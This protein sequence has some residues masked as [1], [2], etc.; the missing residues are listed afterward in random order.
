MPV[1]EMPD[2]Q[3][4][5]FPEDT[6]KEEILALIDQ[7]EASISAEEAP[8]EPEVVE[9]KSEE[10]VPKPY[11]DDGEDNFFTDLYKGFVSGA[12]NTGEVG[13][14]GVSTI[15]EEE[16]ENATRNRIKSLADSVRPEGG[17]VDD[18]A[19]KIAAGIG[20]VA[21]IAL[22]AAAAAAL[23]PSAAVA[24][25]V[26]TGV[27]GL[28]GL[29]TAGGEASERAR[30][31]GATEE[32]RTDAVY[33]LPVAAAG[34]LEAL[35]IG[36]FLK[37]VNVPVLNDLVDKFGPEF[38]GAVM[39]RVQRAAATGGVEA[40]Q[41]MTSEILQNLNEKY[42]YNP[43]RTWYGGT[44]ESG[45]VGG[46]TGA[47]IQLATDALLGGK[48]FGKGKDRSKPK[49]LEE[50]FEATDEGTIV[51]TDAETTAEDQIFTEEDAPLGEQETLD[52]TEVVSEEA[53]VTEE[54]PVAETPVGTTQAEV[55]TD[56]KQGL[57]ASESVDVIE[58]KYTTKG[59]AM[60]NAKPFD[61][62]SVA[63]EQNIRENVGDI[64][65]DEY[66]T[67]FDTESY[68]RLDEYQ[69]NEAKETPQAEVVTEAK[70]VKK[71]D[72]SVA[73]EE[74]R[75][76]SI[77]VE[78]T[79][80]WA[81]MIQKAR[82]IATESSKD[83]PKVG[84]QDIL[85]GLNLPTDR[86]TYEAQ[87]AVV[88]ETVPTPIET[89]LDSAKRKVAEG[90]QYDQLTEPEQE[91]YVDKV[92]TPIIEEQKKK[93]EAGVIPEKPVDKVTTTVTP[94]KELTPA[95]DITPA[96]IPNVYSAS[97]ISRDGT[98]MK[99]TAVKEGGRW[100]VGGDFRNKNDKSVLNLIMPDG[101]KPGVYQ[102]KGNRLVF[103]D[104]ASPEELSEAKT[105][106]DKRV[107]ELKDLAIPTAA[108]RTESPT[109]E[110]K[111]TRV[112]KPKST[113]SDPVEKIGKTL[114]LTKID[115]RTLDLKGPTKA[116]IDT[117]EKTDAVI[118]EI[119]STQV[120]VKKPSK[121]K[122]ERDKDKKT[123]INKQL[124]E[125]VNRDRSSLNTVYKNFG[126]PH[127]DLVGSD[128][129]TLDDKIKVLAE[130]NKKSPEYV[131]GESNEITNTRD[132]TNYFKSYERPI[133]AI[134]IAVHEFIAGQPQGTDKNTSTVSEL[135]HFKNLGQT[136]AK[137]VLKYVK[138]NLSPEA[139]KFVEARIKYEQKEMAR[140]REESRRRVESR[141]K[142][143]T[144]STFEDV[145]RWLN[146]NQDRQNT[147]EYKEV[148]ASFKKREEALNKSEQ[149]EIIN[150]LEETAN[151][152]AEAQRT[153]VVSYK[154]KLVKGRDKV[155]FKPKDAGTLYPN[156]KQIVAMSPKEFDALITNNPNVSFDRLSEGLTDSEADVLYDQ[157]PGAVLEKLMT[158][159][160]VLSLDAPVHPLVDSMARQGNL[161]GTLEALQAT[162]KN[163]DL[164]TFVKKFIRLTGTTK[165]QVVPFLTDSSN[166]QVAGLFDPKTNTIKL[167]AE[168]GINPHVI[169]HEM[170]HAVTSAEIA[171]KSS[172]L[173]KQ[174]NVLFNNVKD[175]ID[176]VY[177]GTNL[178]E[179]AAEAASNPK[180]LNKL[181]KINI[182]G[183]PINGFVEYMKI[184]GNFL[185]RKLNLP[186]KTF[187]PERTA[188]TELHSIIEAM[189][190][191]APDFRNANDYAM[192]AT[193]DGVKKVL[194]DIGSDRKNQ[195]PLTSRAKKQFVYK[196]SQFLIDAKKKSKAA[197]LSLMHAQPL[198]EI[199]RD[200]GFGQLGFELETLIYEQRGAMAASDIKVKAVVDKVVAWTK[201]A[202][203]RKHKSALDRIIYSSDY[204]STI[205]QVNP[206]LSRLD[207]EKQYGKDSEKMQRWKDQRKDWN[208]IGDQGRKAYVAMRNAYKD[209]YM[210][211]R[212]V[213]GGQV[214][215]LLK[216]QKGDE[217]V[218][219]AIKNKIFAKMFDKATLDVYFPLLREGTKKLQYQ[220]LNPD[221]DNPPF[222]VRLFNTDLERSEAQ[223][224]LDPE[225]VDM[226][227]VE[228]V[229]EVALPSESYKSAPPLSFAG[230][231]LEILQKNN[232]NE[233]TQNQIMELFIDTLPETSFA[234]S[235]QGRKGTG[236]KTLGGYIEDSLY[237]LQTKAYDLGTQTVRL[238]YGARL[239]D[240]EKR[241]G[242]ALK[243]PIS[244]VKV[245]DKTFV[246]RRKKDL[247]ATRSDIANELV[248]RSKF[249]RNGAK[250]KTV[251]KFVKTANQIAFVYTIGTNF[252][253]AAV[254]LSQIPLVVY[255]Y[256][257]AE[258]GYT[259][260]FEGVSSAYY[261]VTS[262]FTNKELGV[263]I[264][265]YFDRDKE[266][267]YT[268]KKDLDPDKAKAI[269]DLA[270]LIKGAA[271]RNE[272][273]T[274][275]QIK[276]SLGLEEGGR[277]KRGSFFGKGLDFT[278]VWSAFFFSGA[279]KLNRQVTM[280]ASYRLILERL[281]S[282]ASGKA[283]KGLKFEDNTKGEFVDPKNMTSEEIQDL[284]VREALYQTRQT[285]G[286][287]ILEAA[288]R[289]AQSGIGRIALMYKNYGLNMYTTMIKTSAIALDSEKD[290]QLRKVAAKQMAG[291]YVSSA[292][293]AGLAGVPLYGAVTYLVDLFLLDDEE[294][295]ADTLF[296]KLV[297]EGYYKGPIAEYLNVDVS[298]RIKLTDLL[299]QN[300]KYNQNDSVE[301]DIIRVFG[302]PAWSVATKLGRGIR[303][304]YEGET[305]RGIEQMVPAGIA[306]MY[307]TTIG[308]YQEEGGI[309]TRRG[310]PIYDDITGGE[311]AWQFFGFPPTRYTFAQEKNQSLKGIEKAVNEKR[312]KLLK[313][314][315][316]LSRRGIDTSDVIRKIEKFNA[317]HSYY[318]IS[319]DS[320][321]QSYRMHARTS[322]LMHNGV[323]ISPKLRAYLLT[324]DSQYSN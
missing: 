311:L 108:A 165:I 71:E 22:P 128:T 43:D 282:I 321:R 312:S 5:N 116:E 295:D 9:K 107:K 201:T 141:K 96:K 172:P 305:E 162:T 3:L 270:P 215:S 249:T 290:P 163:N 229:D 280:V 16:A 264:E 52:T 221:K 188:A 248:E 14:L 285:N 143:S 202:Q 137:K 195:T 104:K 140:A 156:A 145:Q 129:L 50:A 56:D 117:Q 100:K 253:S 267:N 226:N 139:N 272:L 37:S 75:D 214:D 13:A 275:N 175:S 289:V 269:Q 291:L 124:K 306:N 69:N 315:Y 257:G 318:A 207:A 80:N 62:D 2:G 250:Y 299:F 63:I 322:A 158:L 286:G 41:E 6:P 274:A 203:G 178:D 134:A 4:V 21:G 84:Y 241:I 58:S 181:A 262:S 59:T 263:G 27:A 24:T 211:L 227:T 220:T 18:W 85:A 186:I 297:G 219:T 259:K 131:A 10:Y 55:V 256:L 200:N 82:A 167:D 48:K 160:A 180:F 133:D 17:D 176:T 191:P 304:I 254:N 279:E 245:S 120:V 31:A 228:I 152:L 246:G 224:A 51:E 193:Q 53:P 298:D 168:T 243:K 121:S 39:N 310:D 113:R 60:G 164:K 73:P 89:D 99:T 44:G 288:P 72:L 102:L 11:V 319:S 95:V 218:G 36:R 281:N 26:G 236:A 54:A 204:G 205:W 20:S 242:E 83:G 57:A 118:K 303:D 154:G 199:S 314:F 40:A 8:I 161:Q 76:A 111:S 252:S 126:E 276:D 7:V 198:A 174:L 127:K 258:Y 49:E 110:K 74:S 302:G 45:A 225:Q 144:K 65:A 247:V 187:A 213:V 266:G 61:R 28:L 109:P 194:K 323:T 230:Q 147:K 12:V 97:V 86:E 166:N 171:N 90:V 157:L 30:A 103:Q 122:K 307:K 308:R 284:A 237:S 235:L 316:V 179:F 265:Y 101:R 192:D 197:L 91:V 98:V 301:E 1:I 93:R 25:V 125:T 136:R 233:T 277:K 142:P 106:V 313:Q 105:A 169:M 148:L 78:N 19:Y 42:G 79:K 68:R 300:N 309:F 94:D 112:T 223:A 34:A 35:P 150:R 231:T 81:N 255:P 261:D 240:V 324:L 87:K 294:D 46:A 146:K 239:R 320:I 234:K 33:S 115:K 15:L 67:A 155:I 177:G 130:I 292:F 293:F 283:K 92:L 151:E 212:D 173:R 206:L 271:I 273:G 238:T 196:A 32:Q 88:T 287:A 217:K 23:A 159:D 138:D 149:D 123:E 29:A 183:S 296:R 70:P 185:I 182:K 119:K 222:V 317:R 209:Q 260:A 38:T 47:I 66:R 251:E 190:A 216:E 114:G 184:I 132:I 208:N 64:A 170:T 189:M 268:V 135:A 278:T 77:T 153:G 244:E 210:A 232:I